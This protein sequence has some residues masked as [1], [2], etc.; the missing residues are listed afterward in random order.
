MQRF[1]VKVI[2]GYGVRAGCGGC[3]CCVKNRATFGVAE[4]KSGGKLC[5]EMMLEGEEG[6]PR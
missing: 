2:A 1:K 3:V 6:R 4:A 5:R